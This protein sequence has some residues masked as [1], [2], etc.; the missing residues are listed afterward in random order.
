MCT[1]YEQ[2]LD[3][4][5]KKKWR[6]FSCRKCHAFKPLDLD[7]ADWLLDSLACVALIYTAEFQNIFKQK[8]RGTIVVKLRHIRSKG[9]ILGWI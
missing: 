1:G 8:P 6:A 5:I 7:P 4:A 3:K 2:C 9:G